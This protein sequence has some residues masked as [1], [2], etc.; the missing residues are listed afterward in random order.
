MKNKLNLITVQLDLARQKEN[1]EFIKSYIDFVAE[2]GFNSL[3][4]YLEATVR[5]PCASFFNEETSYSED[6]IR[7]IVAY[8]KEKGLEVFP[9]VENLAHLE[10]FLEY[11]QL[12]FMAECK[13]M[14]KDGRG[15]R[16]TP[17]CLCM[18]EPK[19]REF[20]DTYF[21]QVAQLFES[22]YFEACMDEPFDFMVC[23]KCR[24]RLE[25]GETKEDIFLEHVIHTND[26]LKSLGKTMIMADDFFQYMDV[27]DRLPRDI[28]IDC[29]NYDYID[30]ELQGMWTNRK[31]C[32]SLRR[33][34]QLGFQ[35]IFST[36]AYVNSSLFNHESMTNYADKYRPTGAIATVWCRADN[37]YQAS[38]PVIAYTGRNWSGKAT[39]EDSLKIYT[40]YLG[41]EEAADIVLNLNNA[42]STFQPNNLEICENSNGANFYAVNGL[43]YALRK[44]KAIA[45]GM[46]DGPQKD[47][48]LCLWDCKL[49]DYLSARQH[50][51]CLEA[52]DNYE[53]RRH[54]PAYFIR[55]FEEL[56]ALN[57]VAY[58]HGK[59]MW[60]KY[61][62][63]IVSNKDQFNRKYLG[64]AKR[65]D[66]LIARI[67]KN[68]KHGVFYAEW[69]LHCQWGT[70]RIIVEINYKDKT[71]PATVYRTN[72]KVGRCV[73]TIRFAMEN[74]PV[75]NVVFTVHGEGAIYPAHFRYT[76]GG[77]KYVVSSVTKLAGEAK[78]LKKILFNDT[79]FATLGNNDGQAHFDDYMVSKT[80]HKIKLKFKRFR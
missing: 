66:D 72:G 43:S 79:Q 75:D 29:W 5:V 78:D 70:P 53:T 39:T 26:L 67:E 12:K 38:Y 77:K 2:N 59:A 11:D 24:K 27:S 68:E 30:D 47:N 14:T 7:E 45:D 35:Y 17:D 22:E 62:P 52:F 65:Y 6:E 36:K 9:A 54:K 49:D 55:Q 15:I 20:F 50:Q 32:D 34:E 3:R 13:D 16:S 21:A 69:M 10:Q 1:L 51:I 33:Y 42:D 48:L 61:R 63:G 19:G 60:A 37:F 8:G 4:L 31:K 23:P 58:D 80:E 74:K 18:S 71:I 41:S 56:K 64:R 44:L 57:Q 28:I 73:S 46:E 40:E 25:N 76:C